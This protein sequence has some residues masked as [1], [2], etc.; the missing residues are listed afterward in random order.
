MS[1]EIKHNVLFHVLNENGH[2]FAVLFVVMI[3]IMAAAAA[4]ITT[5][6]TRSITITTTTTATTTTT[7]IC[8]KIS[9][10]SLKLIICELEGQ[11]CKS[12]ISQSGGN[13]IVIFCM[14]R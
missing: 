6:A 10:R 12:L 8:S 4:T 13:I 2:Y 7:T 1:P 11:K 9:P 5:T 3:L 14:K